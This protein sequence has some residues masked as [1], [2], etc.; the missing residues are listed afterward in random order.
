MAIFDFRKCLPL[1][2]FILPFD[3]FAS[4]YDYFPKKLGYSSTN[5]GVTGLIQLPSARFMDEGSMKIGYSSSFPYE[6][7]F[8]TAT[9]FSWLEASYRYNE[10]ENLLYGPAFYSGNQSYKDKGFDLKLKLVEESYLLPEIAVGWNDLAGTGRF[11]AE[12]LSAS[13]QF[14]NLD[15]TL[16]LGWGSLGQDENIKNPFLSFDD[17]FEFREVDGDQGGTFN[18]KS[19][20]SSKYISVFAGFEY[21]LW[22]QGIILKVEYDTSNPDLGYSGLTRLDVNSRFNF[23]INRPLNENIDLGLSFERG[24]EWRLS[25]SVKSDYGKRPL[26]QKRDPPK[27]VVKINKQQQ[28]RIEEDNYIFYRSLNRSLQEES[29]FIQSANLSSKEAEIV[30]AQNRFRSY[31]RAVGRTIRIASALSPESVERIKVVPM[32]GDAEVYSIEVSKDKFTL[33]D[34]KKISSNELINKSKKRKFV[35]H[36]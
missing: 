36:S 35:W 7:T 22:K 27:N 14:N 9:P 17:S 33:Y 4:V 20:F 1:L 3:A 10:V 28:K 18:A 13:K 30:I 16:G 21:Y 12:Y 5:Y 31:P 19:W 6:Y 34:Q 8:I 29:I 32:N 25:F 2:F 23:G 11:A 26:V 24:N 15:L